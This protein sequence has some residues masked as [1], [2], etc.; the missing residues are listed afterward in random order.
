MFE[1]S[2]A[3]RLLKACG[4]YVVSHGVP[5]DAVPHLRTGKLMTACGMKRIFDDAYLDASR[6]PKVEG[7]KVIYNFSQMY[8][9][10]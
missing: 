8:F 7:W 10:L 5:R 4:L 1:R 6:L 3:S 2:Q 9:V